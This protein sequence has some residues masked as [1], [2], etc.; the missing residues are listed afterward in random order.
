MS[1]PKMRGLKE[2][3]EILHAED[4]ACALTLYSLRQL[5]ANGTIPVVR[6]GR[7]VLINMDTLY[8]HLNAPPAETPKESGRV[9]PRIG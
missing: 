2:A 1:V 3:V 5:V 8:A 4:A 7:R 9:V 6:I